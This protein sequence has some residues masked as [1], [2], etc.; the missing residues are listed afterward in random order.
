MLCRVMAQKQREHTYIHVLSYLVKKK[1]SNLVA[2]K[3]KRQFNFKV[4]KK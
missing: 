2:Q 4:H 3:K 1:L